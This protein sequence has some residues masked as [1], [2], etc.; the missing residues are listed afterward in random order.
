MNEMKGSHMIY[1]LAVITEEWYSKLNLQ[2]EDP[3]KDSLDALSTLLDSS[4]V[5][6]TPESIVKEHQRIVEETAETYR[7][8][9][10]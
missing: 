5:C 7:V 3:K 9:H 6:L 2:V 10:S 1:E 4:Y 8:P